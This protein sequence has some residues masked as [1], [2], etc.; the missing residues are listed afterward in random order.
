MSSLFVV[1]SSSSVSFASSSRCCFCHDIAWPS[2]LLSHF[3]E[4]TRG[5]CCHCWCHYNNLYALVIQ[6]YSHVCVCVCVT[7]S[8]SVSVAVSVCVCVCPT[9]AENHHVRLGM[10]HCTQFYPSL[11][12]SFSSTLCRSLACPPP[13]PPYAIIF[14]SLLHGVMPNSCPPLRESCQLLCGF[15]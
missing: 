4:F 10:L 3:H 11:S 8:I 7:V 9:L 14:Y 6:V 1:L 13:T 5:C 12:I 15:S 2:L